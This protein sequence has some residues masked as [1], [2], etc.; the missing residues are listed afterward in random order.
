MRPAAIPL[1]VNFGQARSSVGSGGSLVNMYAQPAATGALGETVLL[2][3]PGRKPAFVLEADP[4]ERTPINGMI[5]AFGKIV[6]VTAG[7]AYLVAQDGTITK[8]AG[9]AMTGPVIMAFNS[10]D[11]AA[12][13]GT[14]GFWI[15]EDGATAIETADPDMEV[16]DSCAFLD[17]YVVFNRKGTGQVFSTDLYS[18]SIDALDFA[19]AEKEP[20]DAVRVLAAGDNLW[21]FGE[22]STEVWYNAAGMQF[23]FARISGATFGFGISGVLTAVEDDGAVIW[24]T[25]GGLVMMADGLRPSRISDEQVE[26][27]LRDRIAHWETARAYLFREEGHTFYR[28]TVGDLTLG[29]DRASGLWHEVR[30]YSRGHDLARCYVQAWGR[31]FVGDDQGRIL[32]M[33]S[34][35]FDDAGEP[36]VSELVTMPYHNST[37]WSS[38][39][40][41]TLVVDTGVA[42]PGKEYSALLSAS[43]D[44][45]RSWSSERA[46]SLGRGGDYRR[47]VTWHQLGARKVHNFRVRIG[48]PIRRAIL[49]KAYAR[50]A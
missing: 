6:A 39:G 33:S 27:A 23:P 38:I 45:G 11:V 41:L 29:W 43:S 48:D 42:P 21:I 13:N 16:A 3:V 15:N 49:A 26:A 17:G 5:F 24:L 2:G 30:N 28:L 9:G 7:G 44:G 18:R 31:H 12:V 25:D 40:A 8:H 35:V 20:D 14:T 36:L 50:V 10:I 32:E 4:E 1:A 47:E 46:A 37:L 19:N 22:T 34:N